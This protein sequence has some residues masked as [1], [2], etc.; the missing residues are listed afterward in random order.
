MGVGGFG[1]ACLQPV[2]PATKAAAINNAVAE[3]NGF[4]V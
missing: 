3:F 1:G 4:I 2:T